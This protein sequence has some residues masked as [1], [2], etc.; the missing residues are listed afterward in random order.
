M[1]KI[2]KNNGSSQKKPVKIITVASVP[3]FLLEN[4][5]CRALTL[6]P[7][8]LAPEMHIPRNSCSHKISHHLSLHRRLEQMQY[9]QLIKQD[10]FI[11]SSSRGV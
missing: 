2:T 10:R 9:W 6:V 3:L 4:P 5:A 1:N 7:S 8:G 11:P